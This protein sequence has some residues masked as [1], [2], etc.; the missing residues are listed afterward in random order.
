MTPEITDALQEFVRRM[1]DLAN[2]G[3]DQL[4]A[5]LQDI[6]GAAILQATVGWWAGVALAVLGVLMIVY[7]FTMGEEGIAGFFG[8][9]IVIIAGL[10]VTGSWYDFYYATNFPRLV[11]LDY[12]KGLL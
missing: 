6:V 8:L 5:V 9:T 3:A 2:S 4:P 10:L 12:L 7:E 11:V 1:I